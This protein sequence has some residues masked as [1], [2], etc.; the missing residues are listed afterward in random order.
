[1]SYLN[2]TKKKAGKLNVNVEFYV[3]EKQYVI[4][5]IGQF[6]VI[7]AFGYFLYKCQ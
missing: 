3:G 4:D 1:M 5:E 6:S 7:P 2:K